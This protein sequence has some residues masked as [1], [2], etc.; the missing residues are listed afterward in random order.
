MEWEEDE[1][2]W[3][4]LSRLL[5]TARELA[6]RPGLL[7]DLGELE[8]SLGNHEQARATLQNAAQAA[9][10]LTE[11]EDRAECQFAI[12]KTQTSIGDLDG[13]QTTARQITE[14]WWAVH[15]L[16][17]LAEWRQETPLL[18][19][20]L[21]LSLNIPKLTDKIGTLCELAQAYATLGEPD[22]AL[23]L[24]A[25]ATDAALS[26]EGVWRTEWFRHHK[27]L[28][29]VKTYVQLG[30]PQAAHHLTPQI[31]SLDLRCQ[32]LTAIL[33]S[34]EHDED[35]PQAQA[36]YEELQATIPQIERPER[37]ARALLDL[38]AALQHQSI[39][40]D[41]SR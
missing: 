1:K 38:V 32:A 12:V 24:L 18:D 5:D 2:K 40:L 9:L 16:I 31:K 17:H 21:L 11:S 28:R 37:R 14:S 8:Y 3:A 13:A 10:T 22:Q 36:L 7:C 19:E 33:L 23:H 41:W 27:L 34:L 29:L 30:E 39:P 35:R 26:P 6:G 15:A 25:L 4:A 20:A